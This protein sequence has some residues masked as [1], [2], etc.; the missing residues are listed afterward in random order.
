MVQTL[1]VGLLATFFAL[2]SIGLPFAYAQ[3]I[4]SPPIADKASLVHFVRNCVDARIA[5]F[6]VHYSNGFVGANDDI[7]YSCNLPHIYSKIIAQSGRTTK[8]L[9]K[10]TFYP[11]MR[12]ADAYRSN[13]TRN[14]NPEECQVLRIA[15][16]V[17]HQAKGMSPLRAELFFHD[18]L[19]KNIT[20][21]TKTANKGMPRHATAIGAL[22][23]RR[24][25]CQGYCD[26]FYMLCTMYGL[27][28]SMQSGKTGTQRHVW[29]IIELNGKWYAV[30]VTWDDSDATQRKGISFVSHKYFNAPKEILRTT[31][32]WDNIDETESIEPYLDKNY[33]YLTDEADDLTFGHYFNSV[34]D[35]IRFVSKS[36]IRNKRSIRVMAYR[37]DKRFDDI[38]L[39]NVIIDSNLKRA[40]AGISYYNIYQRHGNYAFYSVE[41]K[42]DR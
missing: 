32:N 42:M 3:T 38:K 17:I 29:N 28:V 37:N 21:Y 11:G 6:I 24:A 2:L 5:E 35:A 41:V 34:Q 16:A 14:L 8:I 15:Q 39:V 30:D 18:T 40:R 1:R 19:C 20:Y 23:D 33:F 25:N 7:L 10:L 13:D 27:N 31:H 12:I 26:A 4:E 22:I 36:L 9:Y